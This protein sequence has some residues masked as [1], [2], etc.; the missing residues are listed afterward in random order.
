MCAVID[1]CCP[2]LIDLVLGTVA[3][4]DACTPSSC[5]WVVVVSVTSPTHPAPHT[6]HTPTHPTSLPQVCWEKFCRYFD[7]DERYVLNEPGRYV[8]TAELAKP[9]IDENTIGV[10][11]I[12]GSTY[13]GEFEDIQ[14]LNDMV[15]ECLTA[16]VFD[17]V[18]FYPG[19]V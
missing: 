10:V 13:N 5:V 19:C 17:F 4:R 15:G 7:V 1:V 2:C 9:L 6:P 11:G 18:D 16:G 12:L 3:L 8:M 14:A